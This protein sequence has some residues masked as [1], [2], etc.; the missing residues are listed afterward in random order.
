MA[1]DLL[2]WLGMELDK[3]LKDL[4]P[5]LGMLLDMLLVL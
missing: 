1:L 3:Q 2:L 5:F 4:L